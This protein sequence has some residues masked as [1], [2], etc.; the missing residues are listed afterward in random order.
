M[1]TGRPNFGTTYTP[2]TFGLHPVEMRNPVQRPS[3]AAI[4]DPPLAPALRRSRR[5]PRPPSTG[6]P[7]A[8]SAACARR[9]CTAVSCSGQAHTALQELSRGAFSRR[10]NHVTILRS[11]QA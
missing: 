5:C 7:A 6:P 9:A 8:P 3:N 10:G 11:C 4:N 1:Y 2:Q